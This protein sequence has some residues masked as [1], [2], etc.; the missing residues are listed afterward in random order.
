M[1]SSNSKWV[2]DV[3][4][5]FRESYEDPEER[6]RLWCQEDVIDVLTEK[7]GTKKIEGLALNLQGSDTKS[8]KTEAFTKMQKLKLLQL[9]Y[10]KLTGDH[11]HLSKKLSWLCWHGFSL[12]FIGNDFLYQGNLVSL[13]LRYSNLVQVWE[14]PR[15]LEKLKILNLSHSHY[16]TQ[17]P[18]LSKLPNLEYFIMKDYTAIS[19]VP[20]YI[21][22][23][24]N[25]DYSSVKDLVRLKLRFPDVA[26]SYFPALDYTFLTYL[27]M[28]SVSV[29][30]LPELGGL[31]HLER[32]CFNNCTNLPASGDL[33]TRSKEL[34]LDHCTALEIIPNSSKVSRQSIL[35]GWT[36]SGAS[37]ICLPA[38]DFPGQFV[39]FRESD[40]VFFQVS[41]ITGCNLKAFS[42]CVVCSCCFDQDISPT[43]ISIFVTNYTKLFRFSVQQTHLTEITSNEVIW[44]VN[45]SNNDFTLEGGDFVVV[46]VVIGS[47]FRVKKTG[48]SLVWD[49]K[50]INENMTEC[51]P[52]PYEYLTSDADKEAGQSHVSSDEDRPSKRLSVM[53]EQPMSPQNANSTKTRGHKQNPKSYQR[54][55]LPSKGRYLSSN[56]IFFS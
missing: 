53:Q 55:R 14:H 8:F 39:Y 25:L 41:Q 37:G 48:V 50:H 9:N 11:D 30:N 10:V 51:E 24:K 22:R 2:Y 1:A 19:Q 42:V 47:G 13:D 6:S 7:S 21:G 18:D 34:E 12:K 27:N 46:E 20:S 16:L 54:L 49:F 23:L 17:S 3:F 45:L 40:R 5:S 38:N 56:Y 35:Q 26:K 36:A 33:P 4:L 44:R 31:S 43:G 32:S 29:H 28:E 52:I 15:L